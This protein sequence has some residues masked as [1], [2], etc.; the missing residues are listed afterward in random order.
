M[1]K[2]APRGKQLW[3]LPALFLC[4]FHPSISG[5]APQRQTSP[6]SPV[7]SQPMTLE[8]TVREHTGAPLTSGAKVRLRALSVSFQQTEI[9]RDAGTATFENVPAG[10]Y[11][12]EVEALQYKRTREQVSVYGPGSVYRV[13]L[14][15]QPEGEASSTVSGTAG[16]GAIITPK[17]QSLVDKGLEKLQK[18]QYE[19]AEEIFAKAANLAPGNPDVAHLWGM[20]F[21]GLQKNDEARKKFELAISLRPTHARALV[22]LSELQLAD[23]E[24]AAAAQNLE[25]AFQV[26]GA[27]WRTHY[28]LAHAYLKTKEYA[29]AEGHAARASEL[30]K[31]HGANA[32]FLLGNIQIAEGKKSEGKQT[33]EELLRSFP[34]E[35]AAKSAAAVLEGLHKAEVEAMSAREVSE[36]P[37]ANALAVAPAIQVLPPADEWPWAPEDVDS[38]EYVLAQGV[39][40]NEEELLANAQRRMKKQLDNFERFAATEHI[41]HT[42]ID[43]HGVLGTSKTKEFSYLVF[44]RHVS[45]DLTFLDE[46]RDGGQNLEQFP[47]QLATTGLVSIG[48]AL[49]DK[50]YQGDF[51]YKCE[52]LGQWRGQPAWQIHW[53]QRRD[54]RSRIM[55]WKNNQGYYPIALRGRL[56]LAA[57]TFDLLHLEMDL[58]ESVLE[59][60][61]TRDHL[62]VDYG[63]VRFE[64]DSKKLWLPWYAEMFL[65]VRGKRYRHKHTL[66]NYVL[67]SVETAD[68]IGAPKALSPAAEEQ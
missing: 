31:E 16:G 44:V 39:A 18:K 63:A 21:W 52:G 56:W 45:K 11:E 5:A 43:G 36:K 9:T 27:D 29:K 7:G 67:F 17:L 28:L 14:Y 33:L 19:A 38:K 37:S 49:L 4:F 10:D 32:R 55:I 12:V 61:L 64:K 35:P 60:Q 53:V 46:T 3:V 26:N 65:E 22:A 20:A 50:Q 57:N 42:P 8:V 6:L 40:C 30:A 34:A 41:E 47:T 66:T 24:G 59:L 58:R 1:C 15:V 13:Y 62:T 54:K 2:I 23:G 25:K 51:E 48:V 68:Q